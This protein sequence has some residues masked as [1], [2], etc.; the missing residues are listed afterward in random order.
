MN[1]PIALLGVP[2]SPYTRKM[3]ALMR[4]RRIPYRLIIG[5][6]R[7]DFGLPKPKV[8]LLPTFYLPDAGGRIEPVVD[9]TP[10]IRR[11]ERDFPG[12]SALPRD[13]ALAFLDFLLEDWGDEWLTKA[14]F[15]YR[16]HYADDIARGREILP[17]W[18]VKPVPEDM[19]APQ[20]RMIGDRQIARLKV[21]GSNPV[22]AP[23][24]E[25]SYQR[26][27]ALA[28]R[29]LEQHPFLLGARPGA[30]DF[31]V[32]G[33]LTQLSHFDPT[34]MTLTLARAP[35]IYAWVDCVDDLSGL[36]PTDDDWLRSDA[37]PDT[38]R[39][40]FAEVGRGYVPVMLANAAAV[41]AG[42]TTVETEV[43]G[44][45]WVQEPFPYQAR[46]V[47]WV[48][49]AYAALDAGAR[50]RVD[51]VLRGTGCETLVAP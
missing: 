37:L 16:W 20:K 21:V 39:A 29:H 24:I 49:E 34:P 1:D 4:Y 27:L 8:A 5:S 43:D 50:A 9:S 48:R 2:G 25:A 41:R 51:G 33:Q 46:C 3:L 12:R 6:H 38:L 42:A 32:Y 40:L 28:S 44:A 7:S 17:R 47:Q 14:M 18:T 13:P 15:H 22:T 26:F 31:A 45:R 10:I 11:L 36:E 19:L 23:I 30:G 35:R